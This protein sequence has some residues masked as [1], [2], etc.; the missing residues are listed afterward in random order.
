MAHGLAKVFPFENRPQGA[1]SIPRAFTRTYSRFGGI[2]CPCPCKLST[3]SRKETIWRRKSAGVEA[4]THLYDARVSCLQLLNG[5]LCLV[6][7]A[8]ESPDD[9]STGHTVSSGR[10]LLKGHLLG[11]EPL[12]LLLEHPIEVVDVDESGGAL[13]DDYTGDG[14]K[15]QERRRED[16]VPVHP[17]AAALHEELVLL[18]QLSQSLGFLPGGKDHLC[19]P[20]LAWALR[21][22]DLAEEDPSGWANTGD[23]SD[24]LADGAAR[25]QVLDPERGIVVGGVAELVDAVHVDVLHPGEL[26]RLGDGWDWQGVHGGDMAR[27]K[28][29]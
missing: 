9:A 15:G 24:Q 23:G 13:D 3:T 14:L 29:K 20:L 21:R 18:G 1:T 16:P 27:G 2:S 5:S 26:A 22:E 10:E 19:R 17:D 4:V 25:G 12:E 7:P 8:S 28:F 6:I 11:V